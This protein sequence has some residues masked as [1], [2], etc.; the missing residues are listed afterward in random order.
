MNPD[1]VSERP[2]SSASFGKN[3][4]IMDIEQKVIKST[5]ARESNDIFCLRLKLFIAD[6]STWGLDLQ[7]SN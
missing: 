2:F 3:G 6:G 7:K 5:K 1:R 4:A